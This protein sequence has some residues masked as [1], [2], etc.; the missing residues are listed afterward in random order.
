MFPATS[1]AAGITSLVYCLCWGCG[2]INSLQEGPAAQTQPD[3]LSEEVEEE[4]F[5]VPSFCS[6]L[7]LCFPRT[8]P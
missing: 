2:W 1:P 6:F 7:M 8:A 3:S 5:F 4:G